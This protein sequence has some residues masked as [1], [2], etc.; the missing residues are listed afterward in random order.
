MGT[1]KEKPNA[2]PEGGDGK[3]RGAKPV[4]ISVCGCLEEAES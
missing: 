1:L 2:I 3:L 4:W